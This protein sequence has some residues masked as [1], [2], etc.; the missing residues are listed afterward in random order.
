MDS[1]EKIRDSGSRERCFAHNENVHEKS[2]NR[3][4]GL[5]ENPQ[6][7]EEGF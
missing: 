5:Y 2:F 4:R 1:R 7:R 3:Q 6:G